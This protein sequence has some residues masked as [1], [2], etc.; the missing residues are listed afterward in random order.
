MAA[1]LFNTIAEFKQAV[2]GGVNVSLS[3]DSIKPT[4]LG[5]YQQH[6]RQWIGD[7]QWEALVA[8]VEADNLTA[9][10]TALTE[11]LRR[12]LA[13]LT[14]YEYAKIGSVMFGEMGMHRMETEERKGAYKYQENEYRDYM[15]RNGFEALEVTLDFL[16]ANEGDYPRWQSAAGY[17]RN[18]AL[19]INRAADFR[20]AYS[21]TIDR[22]TFESLRAMMEEVETF[23]IL[24]VVGQQ[25]FDALKEA[26]ADRSITME[27]QA[28]I[29]L[30]RK[31]TAYF[32]IKLAAI[33][34][35]VTI[36][37]NAVVNIE[38]LEPQSSQREGTLSGQT[39]STYINQNNLLAN[40]HISYIKHFLSENIE[41]Y[42]LYK[43][44]LDALAT[45]EEAEEEANAPSIEDP[46]YD[47][48]YNFSGYDQAHATKKPSGI[49][50]L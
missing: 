48:A 41:D 47:G 3:L 27:Q 2:G 20:D 10:Q 39:L 16:E 11:H 25:Q 40:R 50:R 37:A 8:G 44:Y 26:I 42:P 18:V 12:P 24:P 46:R 19:F 35:M 31:A 29:A 22:Y 4:M 45:A 13:M 9:P 5:V 17:S 14:M 7:S 28:L 15:L 6:L 38:R 30:I 49:K 34:N 43:S 36:K 1:Y 33:Q 32:T 21:Y 23:A